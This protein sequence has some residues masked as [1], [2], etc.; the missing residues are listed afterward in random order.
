MPNLFSI[1]CV[2]HR[3]HLVAKKL[4][5]R[6]H[7][8]LQTVIT[9]VNKI[10][11]HALKDRLFHKLCVENDEDFKCLLFHTEVRWLSKGNCLRR[12]Y[13]LFETVVEFFQDREPCLS[14]ELEQIKH[15]VA[16]LKEIFSKF[17]EINLQLQ[18]NEMTL[19]KAKPVISTF[20]SKLLLLKRNRGR[21]DLS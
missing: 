13:D 18:G 7:K 11:G 21:R 12:F 17:N 14:V 6:L 15:G 1:H 20:M 8:S 9:A 2:I 5:D 19:I 10:K 4:S 16:Y 3:R